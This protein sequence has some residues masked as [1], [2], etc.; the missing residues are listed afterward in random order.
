MADFRR[1]N[2]M[3]DPSADVAGQMGLLGALQ[4]ELVKAMVE[5]DELLS[6]VGE[7]DQ[8]VIQ[9]QRRIDAVKHPD[10][11]RARGARGRRQR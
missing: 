5:R 4:Q 7:G 2:R 10:G 11:G 3:I 1:V 9:A 8:R 6:F